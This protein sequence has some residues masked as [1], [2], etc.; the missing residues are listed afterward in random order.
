MPMNQPNLKRKTKNR[1]FML[2]CSFLLV[3]SLAGIS[4]GTLAW[5]TTSRQ[6]SISF[7]GLTI[8]GDD[9]TSFQVDF[10]R[11]DGLR[12]SY[13]SN[14][15]TDNSNSTTSDSFSMLEYDTIIKEKNLT[16][17]IILKITFGLSTSTTATKAKFTINSSHSSVYTGNSSSAVTDYNLSDLIGIDC[18]TAPNLAVTSTT[19]SGIFEEVSSDFSS[20]AKTS[21]AFVSV[22][23]EASSTPVVTGKVSS[24]TYEVDLSSI[25]LTS[26]ITI[27]LNVDYLDYLV[28]AIVAGYGT[29][30]NGENGTY[31]ALNDIALTMEIA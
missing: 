28:K 21:Q 2:A 26:S 29:F 11:Y 7:S 23:D 16:N 25:D 10:Y 8:K 17:N 6:A 9:F 14:I 20:N 12:Y 15:V 31:G 1:L 3:L 24:L 19:N 22:D 5:F 27:Y 4:V 18:L 30:V 13:P